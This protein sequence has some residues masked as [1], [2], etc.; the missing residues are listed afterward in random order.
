[1][2]TDSGGAREQLLALLSAPGHQAPTTFRLTQVLGTG[3]EHATSTFDV[4]LAAGVGRLVTE[5][6]EFVFTGEARFTQVLGSGWSRSEPESLQT[7]MGNAAQF[8][9]P[10][11]LRRSAEDPGMRVTQVTVDG[12]PAFEVSSAA[13]AGVGAELELVVDGTSGWAL[14]A[15]VSV[16]RGPLE[17]TFEFAFDRLGEPVEVSVPTVW[18]RVWCRRTRPVWFCLPKTVGRCVH[19]QSKVPRERAA[20]AGEQGATSTASSRRPPTPRAH[21]RRGVCH[22][23]ADQR[24]D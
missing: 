13:T 16:T 8:V 10:A 1:V 23:G 3:G 18:P 5:T 19:T 9:D 24:H 22:F 15:K 4:D 12:R 6:A 7:W 21:L 11:A 2:S 17:R 20:R 14:S